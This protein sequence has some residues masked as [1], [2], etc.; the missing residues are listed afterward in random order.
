M[1]SKDKIIE[2]GLTLIKLLGVGTSTTDT[3]LD[4]LTEI[5]RLQKCENFYNEKHNKHY[6]LYKGRMAMRGDGTGPYWEYLCESREA[7]MHAHFMMQIPYMFERICL[8]CGVKFT[9]T[10]DTKLYCSKE[11]VEKHNVEMK[12]YSQHTCDFTVGD[13]A[14]E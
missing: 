11:C 5:E 9:T 4:V 7:I 12:Y 13:I 1:K 8:E 6:E 10:M 3:T 14:K 2:N